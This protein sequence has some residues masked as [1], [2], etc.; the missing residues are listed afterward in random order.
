MGLSYHYKVPNPKTASNMRPIAL[1]PL[2]GKIM[3]HIIG[4]RLKTYLEVLNMIYNNI[5]ENNDCYIIYLDLKKAFD[6]VCHK[7]LIEKLR[8]IG[9]R[10]QTTSWFNSYLTDL[11]QRTRMNDSCSS[12]LP[13]PYGVP[14]GSILGPTLFS[15]Y[16]NDLS[17]FIDCDILFYADDTVILSKDHVLL[18]RNLKTIYERC[19]QNFLTINGKKSQWMCTSLIG[20]V[21]RPGT[22]FTLGKVKLK[23]VDEY[24]YLGVTIDRQLNFHTHRRM[25]ISSINYKLIYFQKIRKYITLDAAKTIYK[26]TILPVILTME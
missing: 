16:I 23:M 20:K 19:Y 7:L 2:P 22:Q 11:V 6:T 5:N 18:Q 25:V 8:K 17:H 10:P 13:V 26:S 24:K 21:I 15:I 4:A 1:L 9:L 14:Q 3:E 12:Y